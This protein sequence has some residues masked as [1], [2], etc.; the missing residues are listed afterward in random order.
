[1]DALREKALAK[2]S[3]TALAIDF[4]VVLAVWKLARE[5]LPPGNGIYEI[6]RTWF[7]LGI[8]LGLVLHL[9][10][11]EVVLSGWSLGRF[12]CGLRITHQNPASATVVWRVRRFLTILTRFG[13]GALNPNRL[14]SYN[15]SQDL[16]FSSDLAGQAPTRSRVRSRPD[17]S[18]SRSGAGKAGHVSP[19]GLP[20][21]IEVIAGPHKGETASLKSGTLFARSGLFRIGRDAGWAD[22]ALSR[23]TKVS[24]RHCHLVLS[25]G[26][27]SLLDG[28]GKGTG[29]TNG[30]RLEGKT[31]S[32]TTAMPLRRDM[33]IAIGNSILRLH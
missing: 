14:P 29:S 7:W 16:V 13:I 17:P 15:C 20:S 26:R 27:M 18:A 12:C 5:A 22:L 30:T 32:A 4:A 25:N 9:F 19:A 2:L 6:V 1:M 33:T 8:P 10:L 31:V 11:C 21:R 3:I 28:A 24:G 23:D